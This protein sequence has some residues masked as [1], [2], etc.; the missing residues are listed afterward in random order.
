MVFIRVW[1]VAG[2]GQRTLVHACPAEE[3]DARDVLRDA[4]MHAGV[5]DVEDAI[6]AGSPDHDASG[7]YEV[8][9]RVDED[10]KSLRPVIPGEEEV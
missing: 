5:S 3:E 1:T 7:T 9:W 8:Y 6:N 10:P 4:L 2:N